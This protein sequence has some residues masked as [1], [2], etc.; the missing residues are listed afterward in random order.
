MNRKTRHIAGS[1]RIPFSFE[2]ALQ[3]GAVAGLR[4]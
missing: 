2:L 1:R 3:S 4:R